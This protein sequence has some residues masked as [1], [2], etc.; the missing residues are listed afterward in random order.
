MERHTM[1]KDRDG[2]KCYLGDGVYVVYDGYGIWMTAENGDEA[3]DGI[4]MEP[5]VLKAL[6]QFVDSLVKRGGQ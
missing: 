3:T 5:V 4:Y 1:A 6:N 2:K